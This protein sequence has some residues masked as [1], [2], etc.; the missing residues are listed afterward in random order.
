[1]LNPDDPATYSNRALAQIKLKDF[2][3]AKQDADKALSLKP[4]Y[5]KAFHRLAKAYEGLGDVKKAIK[6][7]KEVLKLEPHN[8]DAPIEIKRLE[9]KYNKDKGEKNENPEE[10]NPKENFKRV[11]IEEDSDDEESEEADKEAQNEDDKEEE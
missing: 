8:N 5:I 9:D 7:F 10:E 11:Q 1:M 4:D 6:S 3:K 2:A